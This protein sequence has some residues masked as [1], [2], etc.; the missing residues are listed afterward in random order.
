MNFSFENFNK[1]NIELPIVDINSITSLDDNGPKCCTFNLCRKCCDESCS[2]NE[3]LYPVVFIHGHAFNEANSPEYSMNS[4]TEI[5]R[6]LQNDGYINAGELNLR[7]SDK[8]SKGE[9]GKS[10]RTVSFRSSYYYILHYDIKGLS[11]T[12]QKSE[13]IENYAIRLKEIIDAVKYKTGSNKVNIVAHSM[14]GLVAREYLSLF[15]D[16]NVNK[17]ILINTPNNGVSGNV[18]KLCSVIGSS[19]ECNDMSAGSIFLSRLNSKKM[20]ENSKIYAIRSTGCLMEENKIGDGIVTNK[21]AY[22]E[23]AKNYLIRGR[24]TDSLQTDLHTNVLDPNAYPQTYLLIKD[25]LA[26]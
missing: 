6:K 18:E 21:S 20:P 4:F 13:R 12:A 8:S 5:Q 11:I 22:L 10:G 23:G 24:C 9:L 19:K 3:K 1:E 7:A 17:V 16:D 2:S 14:G 26:R 25:I 15:G